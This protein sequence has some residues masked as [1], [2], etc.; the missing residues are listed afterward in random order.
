MIPVPA[1]H[2]A[3][4]NALVNY[5][6]SPPSRPRCAAPCSTPRA[7]S[8]LLPDYASSNA[9]LSDANA[10]TDTAGPCLQ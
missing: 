4:S 6:A 10:T 2:A 1:R 9:M 8:V 3:L 7:V 5:L